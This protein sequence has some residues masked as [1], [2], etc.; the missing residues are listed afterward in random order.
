MKVARSPLILWLLGVSAVVV[1]APFWIIP[2]LDAATFLLSAIM[3]VLGALVW[4]IVIIAEW[5]G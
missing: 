3:L 4:L 2:V 1:S 5:M